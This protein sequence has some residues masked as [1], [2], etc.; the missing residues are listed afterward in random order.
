ML[1][2][3]PGMTAIAFIV[4]VEVGVGV[5]IVAVVIIGVL[6]RRV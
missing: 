3:V 5:G 4:F 6:I 1:L 2:G